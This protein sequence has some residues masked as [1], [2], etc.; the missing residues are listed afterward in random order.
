MVRPIFVAVGSAL[1]LAGCVERYWEKPGGTPGEWEQVKAACMLE[2]AG[3]VPVVPVYVLDPG[4]SR[5]SHYCDKSRRNCTTY[6]TVTPPS[7][8][9]EDANADLRDQVVR[10]CFARHG[11]I[12][13][14]RSVP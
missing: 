10:G 9:Q 14:M 1:L 6:D 12:E 13:K 7:Y 5:T 11:W 2:G 4:S 8:R 3:K